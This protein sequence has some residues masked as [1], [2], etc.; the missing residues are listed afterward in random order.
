MKEKKSFV[1]QTE[2]IK[3]MHTIA[4]ILVCGYLVLTGYQMVKTNLYFSRELLAA[5]EYERM[6]V[7][8][9]KEISALAMIVVVYFFGKQSGKNEAIANRAIQDLCMDCD[10]T[11]EP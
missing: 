7:G 2:K 10:K 11:P 4:F 1:E 3:T 5:E 9:L 6:M 8:Y